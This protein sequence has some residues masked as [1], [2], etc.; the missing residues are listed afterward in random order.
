MNNMSQHSRAPDDIDVREE[1]TDDGIVAA[2][3]I[4]FATFAEGEYVESI[5]LDRN[6]AMAVYRDLG[7][8]LGVT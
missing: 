3:R 8:L 5:L 7:K 4:E 1:E 6:R 2:G